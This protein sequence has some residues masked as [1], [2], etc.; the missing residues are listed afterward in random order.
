MFDEEL[1]LAIDAMKG[2]IEKGD[3]LY[4]GEEDS[5]IYTGNICF[6]CNKC[7]KSVHEDTF[8]ACR[9]GLPFVSED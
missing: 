1:E 3:C 5:M 2:T 9:L 4:C 6:I 7:Q 8:Y